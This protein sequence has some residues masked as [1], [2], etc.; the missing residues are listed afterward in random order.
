[1]R[2]GTITQQ[3]AERKWYSIDYSEALDP[4]DRL[5]AVDSVAVEPEGLSAVATLPE[6][7]RVRLFISEG[8]DGVVY[9]VTVQ[10]RT[11]ANELWEDEL[12]VRVKEV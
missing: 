3:P 5:S 9:K 1:M 10:T 12:V 11:V 8:Q 6:D 4:G 7:D 2:V